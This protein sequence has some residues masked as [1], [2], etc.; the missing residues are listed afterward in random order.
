MFLEPELYYT[1]N[2]KQSG[3]VYLS[4]EPRTKK[5]RVI[6]KDPSPVRC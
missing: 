3:L 4:E 6:P 2:P 1:F 5:A